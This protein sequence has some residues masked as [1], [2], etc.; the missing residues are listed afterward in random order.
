MMPPITHSTKMNIGCLISAAWNPVVVKI[1]API[2][3]A[4]TRAVADLRRMC[5]VSALWFPRSVSIRVSYE[6]GSGGGGCVAGTEPERP[7]LTDVA[8]VLTTTYPTGEGPVRPRGL[9]QPAVAFC[10]NRG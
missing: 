3:F 9:K 4:I 2:M 10:A 7:R 8:P 1:P 5:R 6:P